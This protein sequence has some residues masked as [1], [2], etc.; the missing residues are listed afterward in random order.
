MNTGYSPQAIDQ[1]VA[2]N[3]LL[4][5]QNSILGE[6]IALVTEQCRVL[7]A[8]NK[9]L[10]NTLEDL[11]FQMKQLQKKVFGKKHT[12]K[13]DDDEPKAPVSR[14]KESYIKD[15]P[16]K[17]QITHTVVVPLPG[18]V[19]SVRTREK[20][21]YKIDIPLQQKQVYQY[22][23]TQ[24]WNGSKWC[25]YIPVP[26]GD[27]VFG[28]N[29]KSLVVSLSVQQRLTYSQI[30]NILQLLYGIDI[31]QGCIRN[32]LAETSSKS[33]GLYEMLREHILKESYVHSDET[34]WKI[35]GENHFTWILTNEAG[36]YYSVG[37]S[38]GK[39][40]AER[41]LDGFRGILISD[42]Y[43]AYKNLGLQR[44]LCFAHLLRKFRDIN[45]HDELHT[46]DTQRDYD[47]ISGIITD[48]KYAQSTTD[49]MQYY[50]F[51]VRELVELS[52]IRDTD[53]VPT[54]RVKATLV[55][56]IPHYLT[57][58]PYPDLP[59][60]NNQAEREL[61]HV[62]IK[63]K[64]SFGSVTK[65]AAHDVGVLLTVVKHFMRDPSSYFMQM[66]EVLG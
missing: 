22:I 2:E 61:R 23:I 26:D 53:S 65:K 39:G 12:G 11:G 27:V 66:R 14:D 51:F 33:T 6:Q 56:N 38:R 9:L 55:K 57:C 42:D 43:G 64:I 28:S 30:P 63:R 10:R 45:E 19:T 15:I 54:K 7:E 8:E 48:L 18:S 20:I 52:R 35:K 44:Q 41:L 21:F 50:G 25:G 49:P 47:G 46:D 16:T 31:S 60:T 58:L 5:Q 62:V 59:L 32:I 13:R 1:L 40:V 34:S 37:E 29:V 17:D 24:Y 4:R 3:T 36:S